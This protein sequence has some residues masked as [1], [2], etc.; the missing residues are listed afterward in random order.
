MVSGR[1][2]I[3]MG[4]ISGLFGVKGWVKVYSY[5]EPRE[6]ILDYSP[7]FLKRKGGWEALELLSGHRQGKGV[8]AHLQGYD[9][10]DQAVELMG[11]EIAV[12]REQL[13]ELTENEYYWND[14][15]GLRVVNLE[16]VELGKI[17]HLFETGANDVVVVKG[18]RERLIPYTWGEVV[19]S[20]D[21]AAGLMVVDWDA[22][23]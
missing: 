10:R 22:D 14:L 21:L 19:R 17:S 1:Q 8:V 9:D 4:R 13:P 2:M 18:D 7:W 23:F 15:Q 20:V 11:C 16:G 3:V 5:A 6:G 12:P